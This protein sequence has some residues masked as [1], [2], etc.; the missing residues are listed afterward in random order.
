VN[1]P[2]LPPTVIAWPLTPPP[3]TTLLKSRARDFVVE[4]IPAYEASGEGD[5]LYLRVE[6][7]DVD[8][9]SLL[10][11]LARR[12]GVNQRD[13]G[14]AGQKDR[15]AVTRQWVSVLARDV[16]PALARAV[17]PAG[18]APDSPAAGAA[19]EAARSIVDGG[20]GET[21]E[22]RL[23]EV[24]RHR[25]K[26]R[27]GHLAGNRFTVLLRA[28]EGTLETDGDVAL[29]EA[30]TQPWEPDAATARIAE[31][32]HT[33]AER[34]FPNAFG[35]Q[36]F[37]GGRTLALGR[38][39]LGGARVRD[40]RKRKLG[41]SALQA[42]VFN[43][44]LEARAADG[45]LECALE[46][47]VLKRRETGGLFVC[48]EPVKDSARM[49]AGELVVTGPLPG[50]K[51]RL[52]QGPAAAREEAAARA[53]GTSLAA[54]RGLGKD[55]PGTRRPALVWPERVG[56]ERAGEAVRVSF[57]LPPGAYATVLLALAAGA[58]EEARPPRVPRTTDPA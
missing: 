23:L 45:L 25:N 3:L 37:G 29:A 15:R 28:P 43:R 52:A 21:G 47:D 40:R 58:R 5:F 36:R 2:P 49:A 24:R 11:H 30:A 16:P 12:L 48:E 41:V 6:K 50:S 57:T 22:V 20:V 42:A 38:D 51:A 18:R 31:R 55:G 17:T 14:V 10:R 35:P 13:L 7:T 56:V 39:V 4:E 9:M 46:G 26:I 1:W 27:V 44:W 34:G 8:A 53:A 33:L 32:L 19:L 54:F